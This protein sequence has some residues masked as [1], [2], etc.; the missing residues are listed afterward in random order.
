[1]KP[2]YKTTMVIWSEFDPVRETFGGQE[3]I[4]DVGGG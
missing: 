3:S 4:E 2:L 1:M